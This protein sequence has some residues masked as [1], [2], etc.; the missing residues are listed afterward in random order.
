METSASLAVHEPA[1]GDGWVGR[2]IRRKEDRRL[3][4]G[5]GTYLADLRIPGTLEAA[6]LRSTQPHARIVNLDVSEARSSAGVVAVFTGADLA[7]I[8]PV[9]E[10]G[11]RDVNPVHAEAARLEV[12]PKPM[13]ALADGVVRF[14]G[15]PVAVVVA[16]D[17]S[18]AEDALKHIVV[19]YDPLPVVA[20]AEAGVAPGAPLLHDDV[21]GNVAARFLAVAGDPDGVFASG[22][23]RLRERFMVGRMAAS[24]MEPRGILAA[25]DPGRGELT[26]WCTNARPHLVRQY[27][28]EAVGVPAD[29]VRVLPTDM[30]GSFGTGMF[31]EDVVV[32]V[33]AMRLGRPVRWIEDRVENLA[34]TR[35][36]RD[37]VHEVE[38]AYDAD[39]RILAIR[40]RMLVDAGAYNMYVITVSYNVAAHFRNQYHIDHF[41]IEGVNVLTNRAPVTP[42]RGAGRPEATFVMDRV[43]DLVADDLGL[44]PAE[45]RFRNLIPAD[46]M[47]YEVGL[48]YRDGQP[49]VY[50]NGDYPDQLRR[51]LH[52]FDY[53][54]WRARQREE[55]DHGRRIGIG[56]SCFVE[57]SGFGPFEGAVVRIDQ[58]GHVMVATGA[59]PHGQSL[60]T[61]LAQVCA[62]QLGVSPN[63]VTVRAGD[64]TAI[65]FGVGTFA[66]R[67]AVTAGTAVGMASHRVREK[68]LAIAALLLEVGPDDLDLRDGRAFPRGAPMRSVTLR[69]IAHVAAPGPRSRLPEGMEPGLEA[70]YYFVPPAVTFSSGTH[71]VAVEVDEETGFVRPLRYVSVDDCGVMLNPT[72]VEGQIHGGIAH[73]IGEALLEEVVYGED[74][75][76]LTASYMDYLLPTVADV[77]EIEVQHQQ[78]PSPRNPL[79]IKGVGEGGA[80]SPPAAIANAVADAMKP[81]RLRLTRVP[82]TPERVLTAIRSARAEA[83]AQPEA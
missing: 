51:A 16:T 22:G 34:S 24:A 59:R 35:H 78:F 76:L 28:S 3:V 75:Q 7:G 17:R 62:D 12:R 53:E 72:V 44:D 1:V 21:P 33:L 63:E 2:R 74:G 46:A 79:G 6:F 56:M 65:P 30:G 70:T 18:R 73:G 83:D 68:V 47:P 71:V 10:P 19:E 67:S 41:S 4:T 45:I 5:Q 81:L 8:P 32:P 9:S 61:T 43:L 69:E 40:D 26:V 82:L 36:G 38:V 58:N 20:D 25:P 55:R 27:V 66:S 11:G 37:Q 39:G 50:D 48:L 31:S 64:T 80:V 29:S 49:I 15:Q 77:P 52:L 60:E 57:G 23:R 14:V 13:P 54:G 42:V